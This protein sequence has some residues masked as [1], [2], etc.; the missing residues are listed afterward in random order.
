MKPVSCILPL[1]LLSVF[2]P[3]LCPAEIDPSPFALHESCPLRP[4][5]FVRMT[6]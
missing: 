4:S 3:I 6:C 2:L 5:L 1:L